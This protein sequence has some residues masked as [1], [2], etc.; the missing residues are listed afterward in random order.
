[1]SW[2]ECERNFVRKVEKDEERIKSI[3]KKAMQRLERA[4][5]TGI[6]SDNVSFVVED[7]YEVVRMKAVK[8]IN[9][10]NLMLSIDNKILTTENGN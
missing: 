8:S 1:M 5:N 3:V 10:D 4:K 7:Y 6:N 2:A 9:N